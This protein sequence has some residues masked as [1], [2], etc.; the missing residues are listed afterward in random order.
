M[1]PWITS[2]ENFA[3]P[4]FS[5]GIYCSALGGSLHLRISRDI[6]EYNREIRARS[7]T[8]SSRQV[9]CQEKASVSRVYHSVLANFRSQGFYC[10]LLRPIESAV[11]SHPSILFTLLAFARS[12]HSAKLPRMNSQSNLRERNTSLRSS[13]QHCVFRSPE[14]KSHRKLGGERNFIPPLF[15]PANVF[16]TTRGYQNSILRSV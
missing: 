16:R 9:R 5:H 11:K 12:L 3:P 14:R 1:F 7:L 6:E 10:P 4:L 15:R 8:T 2:S 13:F